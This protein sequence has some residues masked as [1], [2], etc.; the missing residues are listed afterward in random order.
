MINSLWFPPN[1]SSADVRPWDANGQQT[2]RADNDYV[3]NTATSYGLMLAYN[4]FSSN[5]LLRTAATGGLGRKGAQRLVVLETDGM[6]NVS[7]TASFSS[8]GGAYNSY[9][10]LSSISLDSTTDPGQQAQGVAT[11]ICA[12]TTDVD[13]WPRLRHHAQA[14][15]HS[16][17]RLRFRVR[18]DGHGHGGEATR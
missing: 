16:L 17:H 8:S 7:T 13:Q 12:L 1:S 14:G 15:P 2:P 18:S 3:Y 11:R 4:Q 6:A 9:Y 5:S 10:D